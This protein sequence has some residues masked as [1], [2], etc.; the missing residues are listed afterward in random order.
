MDCQAC[1]GDKFNVIGESC[2]GTSLK[3][4]VN[5]K[6]HHDKYPAWLHATETLFCFKG[7][8]PTTAPCKQIFPHCDDYVPCR[9]VESIKT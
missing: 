3:S 9:Y 7:G 2:R 4:P 1:K 5:G 8:G 6:L